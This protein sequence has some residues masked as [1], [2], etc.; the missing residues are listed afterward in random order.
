M[1]SK[2]SPKMRIMMLVNFLLLAHS[3]PLVQSSE[4]SVPEMI[5]KAENSPIIA[6]TRC[7]SRTLSSIDAFP[8][9]TN[10]TTDDDGFEKEAESIVFPPYCPEGYFCDLSAN[11]NEDS[12][13]E[14]LGL[15]KACSGSTD[16]CIPSSVMTGTTPSPE[17]LEYLLEKAVEEECQEQCGERKNRCSSTMDCP[18]SLFCNFEDG[19]AGGYCEVCPFH[20]YFC[21]EEK[22]LT[23]QGLKACHSSCTVGCTALGTLGISTSARAATTDETTLSPVYIDDVKSLHGSPQLSATGPIVDCGLGLE[24]CEGVEGSVCFIERGKAPFVNKTRNCHAGGGIA[25]V[26]YNLEASCDNI[27]GSFFG[28]ETLIPSVSLTHIEA[29]AILDEVKAMPPGTPLLATVEVGGHD[30]LPEACILSCMEDKECEGTDL[31]CNFDNGD[32]GDCKA[33]ESLD[34]CNDVASFLTDHLACTAERE[35]CDFSTGGRGYCRSCPEKDGECFFSSLSRDG[36]KECNSVC[37]DGSSEQLESA[38]CKFC[39]QGSFALG[40]IGDGFESTVIDDENSVATPCE[41]CA[42]SSTSEC[43]SIH[44]WDMEYPKRT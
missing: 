32:F 11:G 36:A 41:F 13:D 38:K 10:V 21:E 37:T 24:P 34:S 43:S 8:D 14:V 9:S 18:R 2:T 15:C 29:K 19:E 44:R 5:L 3:I 4:I 6:G 42:S 16:T 17:S 33:T 26:I 35:Y 1:L 27:D 28:Q 7:T 39:A 22:N 30:V 40:D 23:S 12:F 20:F 25:A 31:I